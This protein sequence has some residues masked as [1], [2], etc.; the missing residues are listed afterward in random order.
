M[1]G[2]VREIRQLHYDTCIVRQ[3]AFDPNSK[4]K[5]ASIRS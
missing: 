1:L 5:F 3:D 2:K 4:V